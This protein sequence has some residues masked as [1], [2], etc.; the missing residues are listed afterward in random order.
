M[1]HDF[2][3]YPIIYI[4]CINWE[5]KAIRIKSGGFD[6]TLCN[7]SQIS[8]CL[9][10]SFNVHSRVFHTTYD[11]FLSVD[12]TN[13]KLRGLNNKN[14]KFFILH[15]CHD[16]YGLPTSHLNYTNYVWCLITCAYPTLS[17][18]IFETGSSKVLGFFRT[19]SQLWHWVVTSFWV[20]FG[21]WYDR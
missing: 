11:F 3:I 7:S 18:A 19:T 15:S 9:T 14:Q 8:Q 4:Y 5:L 20:Q 13:N 2:C 1:L 16:D 12:F 21:T 17:R 10:T 6:T